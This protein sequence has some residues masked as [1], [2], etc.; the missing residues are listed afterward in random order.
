[1]E[2]HGEEYHVIAT[3]RGLETKRMITR[4]EDD[5]LYW[6]ISEVVFDLACQFEVEHH[7]AGRDYRRQ[8]FGKR[9][10]LLHAINP[11]WALRERAQ[12]G[13]IL[14]E[15]APYRDNAP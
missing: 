3:D 14:L 7:V 2:V 5:A 4:S 13:E 8:I 1:M 12:I 6:L 10:E 9:V 15:K 11:E